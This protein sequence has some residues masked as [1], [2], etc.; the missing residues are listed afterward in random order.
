MKKLWLYLFLMVFSIKGIAN[1]TLYGGIEIGNKGIKVTIIDLKNTDK[2]DFKVK[3]FWTEN[4]GVTKPITE[5]GS[6]TADGINEIGITVNKHYRKL[7]NE[8]NLID[9]HIF[10]VAS[11][12]IAMSK[13]TNELVTKIKQLTNKNLDVLLPETESKLLFEGS[14]PSNLIENALVINIGSG[15]T[16]GAYLKKGDDNKTNFESIRLELGTLSLTEKILK[17]SKDSVVD[18]D[19]FNR[20]TLEYSRQLKEAVSIMFD[21]HKTALH[22]SIVYF[23]GGASWSFST[24]FYGNN[25]GSN[26]MMSVKIQDVVYHQYIL[27]NNFSK[28]QLLAKTNPDVKK[29]LETYTQKN[30]IAANSILLATLEKFKNLEAKKM[31]YVKDSHIAW[32][33]AYVVDKAKG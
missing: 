26:E 20:L 17:T 8:F 33:V 23:S 25:K 13:N 4:T 11:S 32:L 15:N 27:Q 21:N 5:N 7:L 2:R 14:V 19:Q 18:I 9:S 16:N 29:V 3:D 30:L 22:K 12:G 1:N 31:Y 6:L 28:Y 10:I 24:L